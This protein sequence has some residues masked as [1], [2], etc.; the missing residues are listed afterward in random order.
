MAKSVPPTSIAIEDVPAINKL[1]GM[2]YFITIPAH[3]D[4]FVMVEVSAPVRVIA[5]RH[6]MPTPEVPQLARRKKQ[7]VWHRVDRNRPPTVSIKQFRI[8]GNACQQCHESRLKCSDDSTRPCVRCIER[9]ITDE[10]SRRH[11]KPRSVLDKQDESLPIIKRNRPLAADIEPSSSMIA[12]PVRIDGAAKKAATCTEDT[13]TDTVAA[14]AGP[15]PSISAERGS[16]D[17]AAE[18]D[19]VPGA[20]GSH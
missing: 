1:A 18:I 4:Y 3:P 5:K 2:H 8:Q 7:K 13:D 15:G 20:R 19:S 6:L 16:P 11:R 9:G 17:V 10:C 14:A 12:L